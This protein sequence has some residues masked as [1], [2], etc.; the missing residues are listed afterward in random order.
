MRDITEPKHFVG[1]MVPRLLGGQ[2]PIYA[3]ETC[4]KLNSQK[5]DISVLL[6][7][8]FGPLTIGKGTPYANMLE[9]KCSVGRCGFPSFLG[10][11]D[12]CCERPADFANYYSSRLV[13]VVHSFFLSAL[14]EAQLLQ[15]SDHSPPPISRVLG[16]KI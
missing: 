15:G 12:K 7:V 5:V 6:L 11:G 3:G 14:E 2:H 10:D 9:A 16:A 13:V 4:K 8:L 1:R